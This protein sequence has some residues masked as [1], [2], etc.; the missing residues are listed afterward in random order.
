MERVGERIDILVN[1]F[2]FIVMKQV[3]PYMIKLNT[4]KIHQPITVLSIFL[5]KV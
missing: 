4:K 3:K 1:V 2:L 5:I